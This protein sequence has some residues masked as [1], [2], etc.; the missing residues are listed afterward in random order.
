VV[1]LNLQYIELPYQEIK[2]YHPKNELTIINK[3]IN[4]SIY[5]WYYLGYLKVGTYLNYTFILFLN[6]CVGVSDRAYDDPI[7]LPL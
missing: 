3:T 5:T 7:N 6:T 2:G 4:S 1:V